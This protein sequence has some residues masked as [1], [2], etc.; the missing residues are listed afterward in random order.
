MVGEPFNDGR[1]SRGRALAMGR[2]DCA[3][4]RIVWKWVLDINHAHEG[5]RREVTK[6]G[7]VAE[8]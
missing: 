4:A 1:R 8:E 7:G 2:V 5:R 3:K 6:T